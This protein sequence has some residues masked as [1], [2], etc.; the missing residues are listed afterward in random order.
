MGMDGVG[1]GGGL[2]S[3]ETSYI[4]REYPI[5]LGRKNEDA[6]SMTTPR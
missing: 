2:D 6:A 3:W 1:M 5:S 4:A